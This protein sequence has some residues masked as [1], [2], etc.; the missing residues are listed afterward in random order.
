M[1]KAEVIADLRR[2]VGGGSFI[3]RVD[4]ARY[5]NRKDAHSVDRYLNGLQKIDG[6]YFVGDVADVL[7]FGEHGDE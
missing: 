6:M 3:R 7:V 1:T 5:M 4:L 2:Y